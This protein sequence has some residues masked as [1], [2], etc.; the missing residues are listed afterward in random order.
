MTLPQ[1][2]GAL[3]F[4]GAARCVQCHAVSGKSNEMFSD[5][6]NRS[7]AV[8]QLSPFFGVGFGNVLFDGPGNNEDFGEEQISGN[9]ADRYHFRTA[10]LRNLVLQPAYFHDGS[11]NKLE[12]AVQ[13]HLNPLNSLL[14]YTAAQGGLPRDLRSSISPRAPLQNTLDPLLVPLALNSS[15]FSDLIT[16]LKTGL[17][18]KRAISLCS[19]I[20]SSLPS[21]APLPVFE[22]CLPVTSSPSNPR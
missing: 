20:P 18:D 17:L 13:H 5:F 4:F 3:L 6:Q 10:P 21:G 12:D 8:P 19:L 7:L 9:S 22:G 11:F 1:K 15:Q 2:R 16:F 14:Q